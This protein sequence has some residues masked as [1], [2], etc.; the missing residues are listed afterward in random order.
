[1]QPLPP[2]QKGTEQGP[3]WRLCLGGGGQPIQRY[4][5]EPPL[6]EGTQNEERVGRP[7]EVLDLVQAR[8]QLE[9]LQGARI[10]DHQSVLHAG[11]LQGERRGRGGG[12][13]RRALQSGRL[14]P[15]LVHTLSV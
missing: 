1:M 5:H 3:G 7:L 4:L 6:V 11:S 13:R 2:Y 15:P 12:L 14:P 10:P 9:D 8:V